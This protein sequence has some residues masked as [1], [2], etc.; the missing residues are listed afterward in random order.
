MPP[1]FR[2]G[3]LLDRLGG[4][5][6][7]RAPTQDYGYLPPSVGAT[8]WGQVGMPPTFKA[9]QSQQA[10]SDNAWL[11]SS[12]NVIAHE[13]SRTKFRLVRSNP[14]GEPDPIDNHQALE[15]LS[16]PQPVAGGRS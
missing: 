13:V 15:T 14:G 9:E 12:I 11:Y 6:T 4:A 10:Y 1:F 5:I 2:Q 7:R 16:R 3:S 8:F